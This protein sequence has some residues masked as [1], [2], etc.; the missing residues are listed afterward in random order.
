[1]AVFF[2]YSLGLD[3]SYFQ[4]VLNGNLESYV[5]YLCSMYKLQAS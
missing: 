2:S 3:P 4:G 5:T 1:M